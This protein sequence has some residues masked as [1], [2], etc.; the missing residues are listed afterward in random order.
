MSGPFNSPPGSV[1][2]Q[3]ST[4]APAS[5][6]RA[7]DVPS[8]RNGFRGSSSSSSECCC[9]GLP[10]AGCPIHGANGNSRS[11]LEALEVGLQASP[12]PPPAPPAS[13]QSFMLSSAMRP[14]LLETLVEFKPQ[15]KKTVEEAIDGTCWDEDFKPF[16]DQ[17]EDITEMVKAVKVQVTKIAEQSWHQTWA[18]EF[19]RLKD[20]VRRIAG[21][22]SANGVLIKDMAVDLHK[23][24]RR[25]AQLTGERNASRARVKALQAELRHIKSG[26]GGGGGG[27]AP[28]DPPRGPDRVEAI[29]DSEA[30]EEEE[31][32]GA[33][34]EEEGEEEGDDEIE[35]DSEP[36]E[37]W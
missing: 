13:P 22:S 11:F 37:D 8:P 18:S 23:S 19:A 7:H 5:G 29:S 10:R 30:G 32:E 27:P 25:N 16:N 34:G 28:P 3:G 4:T 14:A 20:E 6:A 12:A 33:E 35:E 9:D 31:E 15:L 17:L 24:C 26:K 36:E 21:E 2:G 1:R